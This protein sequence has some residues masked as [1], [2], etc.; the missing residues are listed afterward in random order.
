M[1]TKLKDL[2]KFWKGVIIV[3]VVFHVLLLAVFIGFQ[4]FLTNMRAD[5][6]AKRA[7]VRKADS[8]LIGTRFTLQ[9]DGKAL[10]EMNL[11]FPE[12]IES[13][14]L[15]V[16]FNLHGGGFMLGDADEM[17]TQ[18]DHWA[19]EWNTIVVSI[20]YTKADVKPISYGV[21]EIVD[22][23]LYF[24]EHAEEYSAD[25]D[26]FSVIGH[27]AGGHYAAK[28]AIA[29]DKKG[30]SLAAQILMCPW[31][32]GLPDRVS[33]TVAPA[34]FIL[35]SADEISQRSVT[36]QQALRDSGVSVTVKEYEGG[37]HPFIAAPYPELSLSLTEEERS[38]FITE[39]QKM[40]AVQAENDIGEWLMQVLQS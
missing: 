3:L 14:K 6:A 37:L 10:V 24:E 1:K 35:G 2:P 20:D 15:P 26:K 36:Y 21:E 25:P 5:S 4:S 22:T 11:Y 29:L 7:A 9:R 40:L 12:Q 34:L 8:E 27:S 39:T 16:L 23:V 30:F 33:S 38:E 13:Q 31:A 19:N 17:D 28:A 32:T 18:C